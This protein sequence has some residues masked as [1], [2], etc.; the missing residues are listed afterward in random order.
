MLVPLYETLGPDASTFIIN[1]TNINIVF[2]DEIKKIE[3]FNLKNDNK[4]FFIFKDYCVKKLKQIQ[5][6][7]LF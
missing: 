4:R 7:I 2:C 6:N 5:L 1:Q 3:G